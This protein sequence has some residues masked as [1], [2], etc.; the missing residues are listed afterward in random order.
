MNT[1]EVLP[2]QSSI[3]A[4]G[5]SNLLDSTEDIGIINNKLLVIGETPK[6]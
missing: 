4:N 5:Q 1:I 3:L 6:K 2:S